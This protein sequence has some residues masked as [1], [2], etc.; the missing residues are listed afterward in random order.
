MELIE[1]VEKLCDDLTVAQIKRWK[2][3]AKDNWY[4]YKEGR[5]YIKIISNEDPNSNCYPK[6][7]VWGFVNKKEFTTKKGVVFPEGAIMMAQGWSRPAR[8]QPRGMVY[9]YNI[10]ERRIYGPDYLI[11]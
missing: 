6:Q 1:A 9:N 11:S 10:T 3:I 8:N 4:S 5:N 7:S 2:N